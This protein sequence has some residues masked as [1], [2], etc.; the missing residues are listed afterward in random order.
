MAEDRAQGSVRHQHH[1]C[2][3][4]TTVQLS[5]RDHGRI[6]EVLQLPPQLVASSSWPFGSMAARLVSLASLELALTSVRS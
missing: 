5:M 3:T 1:H 2:G 6:T 4:E